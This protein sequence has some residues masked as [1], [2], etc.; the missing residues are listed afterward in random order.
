MTVGLPT[1]SNG[2]FHICYNVGS[3]A[4]LCLRIV[5]CLLVAFFCPTFSL[6]WL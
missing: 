1:S 4:F 6:F 2:E 3:F 5:D